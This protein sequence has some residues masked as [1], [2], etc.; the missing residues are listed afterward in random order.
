M[1]VILLLFQAVEISNF[2]Q[3]L[4][5]E[6]NLLLVVKCMSFKWHCEAIILIQLTDSIFWNAKISV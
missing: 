2:N 1:I 6:R 5:D 4:T 3:K